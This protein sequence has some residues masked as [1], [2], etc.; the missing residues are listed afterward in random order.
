MNEDYLGEL[1]PNDSLLSQ[2]ASINLNLLVPLMALLEE[3][4]VSRAAD[5]VGLS[6]PAMSHALKK[7]RSLL[8]DEL[9]VRQHSGMELTP[10]AVELIVPL[11]QA[12]H[13]AASLVGSSG[14]DPLTDKRTIT[15]TMT[16][17]TA[18]IL[19]AR[20]TRILADKAPNM[21][22][23]IKTGNMTAPTIFTD[24]GVD[25]ILISETLPAPYPRERLFDDRWLVIA[26]PEVAGNRDAITLIENEPHIVFEDPVRRPRPY[27]ALEEA[28]IPY[29][30][31]MRLTDYMLVPHF[32]A[33]SV[34]IAFHRL[35]ATE[36][37]TGQLELATREF[38]VPIQTI[39][40]D[41]VWNPWLADD[42]FKVWLRDILFEAAAPLQERY[43]SYSTTE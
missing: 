6:Q 43:E 18:F 19:M 9:L 32:V 27:I 10:R 13:Q 24:D 28:H 8:G 7:I 14:F 17:S 3:R 2:L 37:F 42:A 30:V 29:R 36:E 15:M 12:L 38:P 16:T 22:L 5:R 25:V 26:A 33:Q 1:S 35:Q 23:R 41:L 20:L 34:G 40:V 21:S 39:G 11:K 4:S 31:T